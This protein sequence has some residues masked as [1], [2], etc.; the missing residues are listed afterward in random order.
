MFESQRSNLDYKDM[1]YKEYFKSIRDLVKWANEN[2]LHKDN[3]VQVVPESGGSGYHLIFE[4]NPTEEK[5]K[6]NG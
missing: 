4:N 5:R 6:D 1:L 2:G 3:I